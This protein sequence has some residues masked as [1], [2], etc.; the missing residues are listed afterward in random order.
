MI[1]ISKGKMI[2]EKPVVIL[3][4][5]Y[6]YVLGDKE[7]EL[8]LN[9]IRGRDGYAVIDDEQSR[10]AIAL[11]S[12]NGLIETQEDMKPRSLFKMLCSCILIPAEY[13]NTAEFTKTEREIYTWMTQC[14]AVFSAAEL[15]AIKELGIEPTEDYLGKD[16]YQK[17]ISKIYLSE[18][19]LIDSSL[20]YKMMYV[21]SRDEVVASILSLVKKGAVILA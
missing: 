4:S 7:G 20:E 12:A 8:W 5:G 13:S 9:A 18:V 16:N 2:K 14:S 6:E 19:T 17:L 15:V 1:Y 11:L 21:D 3:L 10:Q